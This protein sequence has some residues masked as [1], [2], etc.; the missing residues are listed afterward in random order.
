MSRA[1]VLALVGPDY[2]TDTLDANDPNVRQLVEAEDITLIDWHEFRKD[3]SLRQ[4][5]TGVIAC[6]HAPINA[7]LLNL[8]PCTK[9]V[10]NYGVGIDHIDLEE[11]SRRGILVGNTPNVLS[12]ATCDLAWTLLMATARRVVEGDA[13]ARSPAWTRY[14]NMVLLGKD[15]TGATLGI[16]GMGRIGVEVAKR[17]SGFRMKI[18]YCNRKRRPVSEEMQL[19]AEFVTKERLL[20]ESDFLVLLCPLTSETRHFIDSSALKK[21]KSDSVLINV[22]RGAVVDTDALL[23]ALQNGWIAAAGLDV[24]DPEPL[25]RDHPLLSL[26]NVL[27]LPHRGSATL[28]TRQA[29]S[30]LVAQN[31]LAGLRGA[32]LPASCNSISKE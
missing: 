12:D 10:S 17:A 11:C 29:M 1:T 22:A 3:D 7:A 2:D 4:K 18:L 28:Q 31:L 24:T 15:V 6:A 8:L 21:M 9:V 19:N 20:Q 25:P 30:K 32:S 14:D 16:V 5:V 13:L 23:N 27:L 26:S